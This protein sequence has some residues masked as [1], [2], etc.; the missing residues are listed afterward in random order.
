MRMRISLAAG[1]AAAALVLAGLPAGAQAPPPTLDVDPTSGPIG[2]TITVSGT[3]CLFGGDLGT[4][5]VALVDTSVFDT[6]AVFPVDFASVVANDDGTW[7][8]QLVVPASI[9]PTPDIVIDVVPGEDY[10]VAAACSI[11]DPAEGGDEFVYES[12]PFDVT[13]ETVPT[14]PPTDPGTLP[15]APV[16]VPV[17]PQAQPATPVVGDPSYTG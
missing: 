16:T 13:G 2:T 7:T 10:V 17:S 3:G 1:G 12:V 6:E 15:E 4:A 5:D 14:T 11:G 9:S 8:V